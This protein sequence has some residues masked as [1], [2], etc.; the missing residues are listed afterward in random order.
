MRGAALGLSLALLCAC[1]PRVVP[2]ASSSVPLE[3]IHDDPSRDAQ[4]SL[5]REAHRAFVQERYSAAAL[6]FRRFVDT[7]TSG[8]PRL[9]EARWWLGRSYEQMGEY[10]AAMAEYRMLVTGDAAGDAETPVYQQ[11]ALQRLD[12]LRQVPGGL[13][14]LPARR[15]A[16]ALPLSRLPPV[17]AW[18]AWLQTLL[19]IGVTTVLL[20][21]SDTDRSAERNL[22]Q[23]LARVGIKRAEVAMHVAHE[24]QAAA[25]GQRGAHRGTRVKLPH[26]RARRSVHGDRK[27]TRLNSSH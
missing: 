9:A 12:Q 13:A 27:S 8:S 22:P 14:A 25:S 21:P 20:D 23:H 11:Q 5:L 4:S 24:H 19:K 6:F 10:R 2:S 17:S 7:T 18:V 15:V 1:S 3:Q 26:L 16:L